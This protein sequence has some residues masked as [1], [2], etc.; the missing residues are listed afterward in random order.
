MLNLQS[1]VPESAA[2]LSFKDLYSAGSRLINFTVWIL[3]FSAVFIR[4]N[5]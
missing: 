1:Y 2:T 3:V 4:T 5:S